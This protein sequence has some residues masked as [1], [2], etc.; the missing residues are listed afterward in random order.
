[1]EWPPGYRLIKS[2]TGKKEGGSDGVRNW[3]RG[4]GGT[5][6]FSKGGTAAI[7]V[8]KAEKLFSRTRKNTSPAKTEQRKIG[9]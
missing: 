6:N 1:M 5:E 8:T 9:A 4:G 2:K 3:K 7:R